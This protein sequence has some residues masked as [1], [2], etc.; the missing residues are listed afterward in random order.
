M[1]TTN[2]YNQ[3]N[4]QNYLFHASTDDFKKIPGS[5]I[6][7]WVSDNIRDSFIRNNSLNKIA[8]VRSGLTSGDKPRFVKVWSEVPLNHINFTA[9][10][11]KINDNKWFPHN[12]GG[13]ARKWFGNRSNV[14]D[15]FNNGEN[16]KNQSNSTI[17]NPSY[18][19]REGITWTDVSS[20]FFCARLVDSGFVFENTGSMLFVKDKSQI[21]S[22]LAFMCSKVAFYFMNI[23]NPTLHFGVGEVSKLPTNSFV[24]S[25]GENAKSCISIA[26]SDW[27][28]YET[29]WDFTDNPLIRTQQPTLEKAF[30]TWQAQNSAAVAEMKRLEEETTAYLS[31]LMACK[32]S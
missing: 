2:N 30:T 5:P 25:S 18:F 4:D 3:V 8:D 7:Y 23:M 6:A 14:I 10:E 26:K 12:D 31:M 15:W 27:D 32:M 17:R 24:N 28:A 19:F 11:N 22:L 29:S 1:N 20:S 21:F 16:I 13:N 9:K